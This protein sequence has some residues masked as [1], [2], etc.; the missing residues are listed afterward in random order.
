MQDLEGNT[1][2][3][4][5]NMDRSPQQHSVWQLVLVHECT[6]R[7]VINNYCERDVHFLSHS[8]PCFQ[9]NGE[10][11]YLADSAGKIGSWKPRRLY[12]LYCYSTTCTVTLQLVL[13]L[14]NLYCY[15]AELVILWPECTNG[16]WLLCL[17]LY[18]RQ[19]SGCPPVHCILNFK[20]IL[21][22]V[23]SVLALARKLITTR[24]RTI[25][26]T[27]SSASIKLFS[28]SKLCFIREFPAIYPLAARWRWAQR[29]VPS[30]ARPVREGVNNYR[31][32]SPVNLFRGNIS[33]GY[34]PMNL[35][36]SR[37]SRLQAATLFL[38]LFTVPHHASVQHS[39]CAFVPNARILI[40]LYITLCVLLFLYLLLIAFLY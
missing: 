13:R 10:G 22:V 7:G 18:W 30:T 26:C 2:N 8:C 19:L 29:V 20:P 33:L 38:I 23:I 31:I 27:T 12:N 39:C 9:R 25:P 28:I 32:C 6:I 15:Y 1:P 14:Y 4:S 24:S 3:W 37:S 34:A 5:L 21:L 16:L 11:T 40:S 17:R 35:F 36:P